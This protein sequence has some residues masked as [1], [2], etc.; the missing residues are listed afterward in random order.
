MMHHIRDYIKQKEFC[1]KYGLHVL[2]NQE[3]MLH[4]CRTI[5]GQPGNNHDKGWVLGKNRL[6]KDLC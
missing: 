1:D 5:A 6:S 2:G 3:E 4:S